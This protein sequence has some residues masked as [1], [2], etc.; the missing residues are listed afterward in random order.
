MNYQQKIKANR[1]LR[2]MVEL[3]NQKEGWVKVFSNNRIGHELVKFQIAYWLKKNGYEVFTEAQFRKPYQNV[4]AD[5]F[6]IHNGSG[7]IIEVLDSE[8]EIKFSKK[9]EYYPFEPIPIK[10]DG[11][12]IEKFTI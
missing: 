12:D 11:F 3:I 1:E 9:K 6:A 7:V 2:N 5:I 8:D 4:R 10:V